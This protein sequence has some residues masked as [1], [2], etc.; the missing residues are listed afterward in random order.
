MLPYLVIDYLFVHVVYVVERLKRSDIWT[1]THSKC[2]DLRIGSYGVHN[3]DRLR[4]QFPWGE[5]VTRPQCVELLCVVYLPHLIASAYFDKYV[6]QELTRN[7][8]SSWLTFTTALMACS[9]NSLLAST[10]LQYSLDLKSPKNWSKQAHSCSHS[11]QPKIASSW[12]GCAL[13][14]SEHAAPQWI[15]GSRRVAR[16]CMC[17]R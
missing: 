10:L 17:Y 4:R 16:G 14:S 3:V 13:K 8:V 1:G 11:I 7:Q 6:L 15:W 9:G 5:N 12:R 2:S